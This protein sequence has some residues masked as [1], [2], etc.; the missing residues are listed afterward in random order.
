MFSE[1]P[2]RHHQRR[3]HADNAKREVD[4]AVDAQHAGPFFRHRAGVARH[5]DSQRREARQDIGGQLAFGDAEEQQRHHHPTQQIE[6]R[7]LILP[8]T[9]AEA[10][11]ARQQR[12]P[13]QTPRD[14][15][16]QVVPERRFMLGVA[17]RKTLDMLHPEEVTPEIRFTLGDRQPPGQDDKHA[18]QDRQ[19]AKNKHLFPAFLRNHPR[20]H[21]YHRNRQRQEAFSHDAHAA[22]QTQ[23]N[24][25]PRFSGHG[26]RPC[27]Q[28]EAAHR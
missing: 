20:Q 2:R 25:A 21:A 9:P 8:L 13:G 7:P 11:R 6:P 26:F 23:Q 15:E 4:A 19:P 3:H 1:S 18:A 16:R 27:G 14:K 22:G 17:L 28:P 5:Q 10:Q 12:Q 24:V